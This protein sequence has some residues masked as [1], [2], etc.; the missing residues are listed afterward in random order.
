[1]QISI[2]GK[3]AS[4]AVALVQLKGIED[5]NLLKIKVKSIFN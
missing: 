4:T 5:N 3:F 2:V 1:M